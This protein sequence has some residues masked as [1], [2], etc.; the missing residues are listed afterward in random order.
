MNF[1]QPPKDDLFGSPKSDDDLFGSSPKPPVNQAVEEAEPVEVKPKRPPRA[2]SMFGG[3]DPFAAM[4]K[5][6][7]SVEEKGLWKLPNYLSI[8]AN[9]I[10]EKRNAVYSWIMF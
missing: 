4:K 7:P 6:S 8:C 3:V 10:M 9:D 5:K 1:L 2:V